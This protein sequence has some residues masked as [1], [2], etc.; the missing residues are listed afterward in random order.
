MQVR[1]GE[2]NGNRS[3]YKRPKS[4]DDH[5]GFASATKANAKE[6]PGVY[7]T[8]TRLAV[9][10]N[11]QLEVVNMRRGILLTG[12]MPLVTSCPF[13]L[14]S[15]LKASSLLID[16]AAHTIDSILFAKSVIGFVDLFEGLG[17]LRDHNVGGGRG[18]WT[19]ALFW[20]GSG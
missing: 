19:W 13:F 9:L 11:C 1:S 20:F 8:T 12:C 6:V 14:Q 4:I 17:D 3:G 2:V 5:R 18:A 7:S 15:A 16:N 10:F